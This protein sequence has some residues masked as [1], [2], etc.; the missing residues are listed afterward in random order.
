MQ[1]HKILMVLTSHDAM[2]DTGHQTGFWLEEFTT[3]YYAFKDAGASIVVAS[4]KG[5]KAPIDPNSE[6][7]DAQLIRHVVLTGTLSYK[8]WLIIPSS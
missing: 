2:G 8:T 7:E 5:G 1:Q 4:P 6:A 3:P